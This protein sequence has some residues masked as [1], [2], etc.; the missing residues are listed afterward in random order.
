MPSLIM[1]TC[2]PGQGDSCGR[3][4]VCIISQPGIPPERLGSNLAR[5]TSTHRR[6]TCYLVLWKATYN[7]PCA[8]T[9]AQSKEHI[10]ELLDS[11]AVHEAVMFMLSCHSQHLSGW[12]CLVVC[13]VLCHTMAQVLVKM[14]TTVETC[15]VLSVHESSTCS[16]ISEVIKPSMTPYTHSPHKKTPAARHHVHGRLMSAHAEIQ[17][18][19]RDAHHSGLMREQV[20]SHGTQ[21][22]V[23]VAVCNMSCTRMQTRNLWL[24]HACTAPNKTPKME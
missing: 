7:I 19:P 14:F 20:P 21:M 8:N 16:L 4:N 11:L 24:R 17:N 23:F 10:P 2:I 13:L 9:M 1:C 18:K 12:Q 6:L 15:K 22:K 3:C 5:H